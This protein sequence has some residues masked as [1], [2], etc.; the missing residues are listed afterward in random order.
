MRYFF[1]F[2]FFIINII[3]CTVNG[4]ISYSTGC[5]GYKV[6]SK[7][8]EPGK[9]YA[10]CTDPEQEFTCYKN[11]STGN[12]MR[13][14]HESP[15][16]IEEEYDEF[17]DKKTVKLSMGLAIY[18]T[19]EG[20]ETIGSDTWTLI[21]SVNKENTSLVGTSFIYRTSDIKWGYLECNTVEWLADGEPVQVVMESVHKGN[22]SDGVT[23]LIISGLKSE[24][25]LKLAKAKV[26]KGRLCSTDFK[27]NIDQK[28]NMLEFAKKSGF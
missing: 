28:N 2:Q 12:K 3:G 20:S 27:L 4:K 11:E 17:K 7:L 24:D 14:S 1:I 22:V 19:T 15:G 8:I 6:D 18:D 26:S 23:E 25:F 13:C 9:W 10:K 21:F 16:K 5:N